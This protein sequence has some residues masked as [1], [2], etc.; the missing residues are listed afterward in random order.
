MVSALKN[1]DRFSFDI[2]TTGLSPIDSRP[3]LWQVGIPDGPN[4]V[5]RP[6]AQIDKIY[7][8]LASPKWKTIIHNV[9]FEQRFGQVYDHLVIRNTFCTMLAEQ[10]IMSEK[11]ARGLA[12]VAEKYTGVIMDKTLQKSFIGMQPQEMFSDEQLAYAAQ[13]VEIL[14]EIYEKQRALLKESG[15]EA[16][17]QVEFDCAGVVAAME[18]EG[19][20]LDVVRWRAKI[21]EYRE[22][23]IASKE[24][25]FSLLLDET[26]IPEQQGMFERVGI[27]LKSPPQVSKAMLAVGID[28][29]K[30][31][32]GHYMTDERTLEKIK[33]PAAKEMLEY[34][35]FVKL[36]DS[37]GE[38]LLA[39]IHPFTG[40]IHPDFQQ[41]GAETGRFS[42]R[43]PNMQQ[44]P[45]E[46]REFVGGVEDW[47]IVGADY[48]QMELRIIAELSQDPALIK[49][50]SMG[51]DPHTG[52]AAVMFGIPAEKVTKEQRHVAKTI[53]FGLSYG[54]GAPKLMD[55]INK[56]RED[57]LTIR[58][59]YKINNRY[60]ETYAGVIRWFA[61]AGERAYR[62]G[63]SETLGGRKRYFYRP[64]S[65]DADAFTQ[66]VA[67]I[68]RQG[69][70][71]PIQGTNADITKMALVSVF[72]D[73]QDYGYRAKIINAVHDEIVLLAHK[74]QTEQVKQVVADSMMRSAQE[75]IKSVPVQVD[76][77]VNDWWAK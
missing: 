8:F 64:T 9:K 38:S 40:R 72:S 11:Y 69:G 7:P 39:N 5:I 44:I 75:L 14:F 18:N 56:E 47:K 65:G 37:Y 54:M 77:Y 6:S 48:S 19:V 67:A 61:Q 70:N 10:V 32:K 49:A 57:K 22:R 23:E 31:S 60:K 24:K 45:E 13:D 29:P 16:I 42:C 12:Y 25:L 58:E 46:F 41:I 43:E 30:N 62:Q 74:S 34:R 51:T 15:Q 73:L 33:H 55:T 20:P 71:A 59:V 63:Y 3:L 4:F 52:T 66:Q 36:I 26:D 68:K 1:T 21:G 2:E 27:N 76:T 35:G 17:A 53:N 28:L 50:F